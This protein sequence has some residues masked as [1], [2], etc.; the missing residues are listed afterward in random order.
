MGQ[1]CYTGKDFDE[2]VKVMGKAEATV[3]TKYYQVNKAN[4]GQFP[5]VKDAQKLLYEAKIL[6][7]DQALAIKSDTYKKKK[8]E[9]QN[10]ML[11]EIAMRD[12]SIVSSAQKI[13]LS[14]L[15]SATNAYTK[16]LDTNIEA[17]E[18]GGIV[19]KTISA[20]NFKGGSNFTGNAADFEAFRQFGNMAHNI[21][22]DLQREALMTQVSILE[23][24]TI[25]RFN[26]EFEAF[27]KKNPIDIK[28]MDK[29]LIYNNILNIVGTINAYSSEDAIVIPEITMIG[30][31][32]TGSNVLGR[33]D[34]LVINSDGTTEV[35]DF[36]TK[37]VKDF[38]T[39]S[40]D[41]KVSYNK[42]KVFGEL[43]V[44]SSYPV[45]KKEGTPV[46][47]MS[48]GKRSTFDEWM[49][50]LDI[51]ENMLNQHGIDNTGKSIATLLYDVDEDYNYHGGAIHVFTDQNYYEQART[52]NIGNNRFSFV[53]PNFKEE[54]I[55]RLKNTVNKTLP[56][57]PN[58][59]VERQQKKKTKSTENNFEFT[60]TGENMKVLI[61]KL[62]NIIEGKKKDITQKL[63]ELE[64]T[65]EN[66]ALIDI[67]NTRK[68]MLIS[69]Q[70]IID[71]ND[72]NAGA[73]IKSTN[74]FNA[75]EHTSL[76]LTEMSEASTK[77][78][79]AFRK[80]DS[81][82][83]ANI[84]RKEI[85]EISIRVNEL[86]ELVR[87]FNV[88]TNEAD[89]NKENGLDENSDVRKKIAGMQEKLEMVYSVVRESG[90]HSG[91]DIFKVFGKT[92]YERIGE[93]RKQ[94]IQPKLDRLNIK[95][96]E[97]R[98]G[99]PLSMFANMKNNLISTM[100]K[101]FKK[102]LTENENIEPELAEIQKLER[103]KI[104][105]EAIL[106]GFDYD[107]ESITLYLEGITDPN[108]IVHIGNND[109]Y[110]EDVISQG[111]VGLDQAIASASNSDRAI[112]AP[113][114]LLKNAYSRANVDFM[115]DQRLHRLDKIRAKLL[116]THS[117]EEVNRLTS[118][119]REVLT[120]DSEKN[121][122][123]KEDRLFV[124]KP[125]S[126]FYENTYKQL[127]YN[128]NI[129]RKNSANIKIKI[130][131]GFKDRRNNKI[132]D[133][134]L[135]ALK[136][137]KLEVD[138]ELTTAQREFNKF[139]VENSQLPFVE[140][141]YTLQD[142]L[143]DD[144][145]E[146]T[147]ELFLEREA[148]L[149]N[150]GGQ[151]N[152]MYLKDEDFDEIK[153]IDIDIKKLREEAKQRDPKYAE[154]LDKY[155]ELY[156]Y[157]VNENY[158]QSK[159]QSALS[160]LEGDELAKW[161][162]ENMV[163]KPNTEWYDDMNKLYEEKE[164]LS[165]LLGKNPFSDE[166]T[167]LF[168]E[169]NKIIRPFKING[170]IIPK[171]LTNEDI[172]QYDKIQ[173][174]I[175]EVFK[176]IKSL[177]KTKLTKDQIDV[178]KKLKEVDYRMAQISQ[179]ELSEA[180]T[181]DF[182]SRYY[183][184]TKFWEHVEVAENN[185]KVAEEKYKNNPSSENLQ[186]LEIHKGDAN[187]FTKTF[188]EKEKL[189]KTWYNKHHKDTYNSVS[190]G[191]DLENQREPKEYNF[192]RMPNTMVREKY[193][194]SVPN[195]KYYKIKK[196]RKENWYLNQKHLTSGEIENLKNDDAF[197]IDAEVASGNLVMKPGAY[198][199]N[200]HKSPDGVPLPKGI[201]YKGNNE[202]VIEKGY[203]N[204]PNIDESFKNIKNDKDINEYYNAL[205]DLF[206][207]IQS[208]LEGRKIG[209][210]VPGYASSL[211]E[212]MHS[213]KSLTDVFKQEGAQFIDA[214]F[215]TS[216]SQQDASE[217]IYGTSGSK[218]RLKHNTQLTKDMQSEDVLGSVIKFSLEGHYNMAMQ[219]A[220]PLIESYI[221]YLKV[222]ENDLKD[223][224]NSGISYMKD[225]VTGET[226]E[227]DMNKRLKELQNVISIVEFERRKFVYGQ[228]DR[229]KNR[230]VI[231]AINGI[232]QYTSFIRIGFDVGNQIKNNVAGNIQ[233]FIAA[234]NH[235]GDHFSRRNWINGKR[236][237]Y[238]EYMPNYFKDYGKVT[239][240]AMSTMLYR[241]YNPVQK[242]QSHY[243]NEVSGG[244]T[245]KLQDK[246]SSLMELGYLLQDKGESEIG[247]T[248]MYAVMDN[249]QYPVI[250][251]YD[252]NNEPVYKVDE[253]GNTVTVPVHEAYMVNGDG[254]LVRREDVAFSEEDENF[255][256]N[257]I[258]SEM[259]R[260]QG[261]YAKS[262][263]TKFE[264]GIFGKLTFYFRK[265]FVPLLLERFGYMR[266][267]WEG[268][269]VAMGYWRAL[270]SAVK[271]FGVGQ[272][273]K[274]L[275]LG[276][277]STTQIK[278]MMD[279]MAIKHSPG[280]TSDIKAPEMTGF[281]IRKIAKARRDAVAMS[282]LT[283]LSMMALAYVRQKDDD[284]EE[285]SM[286]EANVFRILW[287]VKGE[288]LS[289]FPVGG[290]SEEYIRNFST[291][292][293]FIREAS[294]INKMLQHVIKYGIV[295]SIDGGAEPDD[296]DSQ[297]Y[298][299]LYK[300]AF[301]VKQSGP[302]EAGTSKMYKDFV[303]LSGF[304]NFR[305]FFDPSSRIDQLK[306]N[307]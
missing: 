283:I 199:E 66:K 170:R 79:I 306:R 168:E 208:K 259:K 162:K 241:A 258:Y 202:Y 294:K 172:T 191:V 123:V 152:M 99:K 134:E 46:E 101:A 296:F 7:K 43:A 302:Y 277:G 95:I 243:L 47:F 22:E 297:Y 196:L 171:Y 180:Y 125:G 13:T 183:E 264:E 270:A 234:G 92:V 236:K 29:D 156:E 135:E 245:R 174:Q 112:S 86:K 76:D 169:K 124:T 88:I 209:Y 184:L 15:I 240:L 205:T 229:I 96:K 237:L 299:E 210:L 8:A 90:L 164:K 2:L 10:A 122:I 293:P 187:L 121:E 257:I 165:E 40:P 195:P 160:R 89:M 74:F 6:D 278:S 52:K 300:D 72:D 252:K 269:E 251:S 249:Y 27:T 214:V 17:N 217:N 216:G 50:Q 34:L 239:G 280:E 203:E 36:K 254:Q 61:K 103:Q 127:Q 303:D 32:N 25:E 130:N 153:R 105:Y 211:V 149:Y 230:A 225:P 109:I 190:L 55:M 4:D 222:L 14:K 247:I 287:S 207:G 150:V 80:S 56:K 232:F 118:G 188:I 59:K 110:N 198:N 69:F 136:K 273:M 48:T 151:E 85:H 84:H 178:L 23:L 231:K 108:S 276:S 155:N 51:Y 1:S 204:D 44:A 49:V 282:V 113:T 5:S 242:D 138:K 224:I 159:Y 24:F 233:A 16:I 12:D 260:E 26:K 41:G 227:V 145:K 213:D 42:A 292:I 142:M 295:M 93:D 9:E 228:T 173:T 67:L 35:L 18:K 147:Q 272:T 305:D 221:D 115:N 290:G 111:W 45:E 104:K 206:F 100:S 33:L 71:A 144:I 133:V 129:L 28:N 246:A 30:K 248:V 141:Y 179:K 146:K 193:M 194:E 98:D 181:E 238:S 139:R 279:D 256:R 263:M 68:K 140:E 220:A 75:I 137:E 54:G 167:K 97:L 57:D 131:D 275:V 148:I 116:K 114:I 200:Y 163:T 83:T 81:I 154:Y 265:F 298:K 166:I 63:R 185:L 106:K 192:E 117:L 11:M 301:Y 3:A 175:D 291:A 281:Y 226:V 253:D 132:N 62:T 19:K 77:A 304:R 20:S 289:M 78:I 177:G 91:I 64:E 219:E 39:T 212:R 94:A 128:V 250:E 218:V 107:D 87:T 73:I 176:K 126:A 157:D 284:D 31:T 244:K 262:D 261:N 70:S 58:A 267:N 120:Y 266:D 271:T 102:D 215:R 286:L 158:F 285:L 65:D 268:S 161:K 60:P 255:I 119:W 53:K 288:T 235:E 186:N 189:F 307:Q 143:P 223:K 274:E 197:D 201:A 21:L 182:D 37:R 38:V 82:E